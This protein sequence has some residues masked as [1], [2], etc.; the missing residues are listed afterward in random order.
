MNIKDKKNRLEIIVG[1]TQYKNVNYDGVLET[2]NAKS[3]PKNIHIF[4][5]KDV[6]KLTD[7]VKLHTQYRIKHYES[8]ASMFGCCSKFNAC[9]DAKKCVHENKLY[10]MACSYRRNLDAGRIFYG[11]N[12]NID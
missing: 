11:K 4:I 7:V 2:K 12:R 10:S 1:N 8:K 5:D 6:N 9:S 3:D